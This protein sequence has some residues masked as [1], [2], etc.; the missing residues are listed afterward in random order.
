[1]HVG[2]RNYQAFFQTV[3]HLL[4]RAGLVLLHTMGGNTSRAYCDPW[5]NKYIFPHGVIPSVSQLGRAIE[6]KFVVE[7][8]HCFG[9]DYFRT[10][11][12]W[13]D[14]FRKNWNPTTV[15][16]SFMPE[17]FFRMWEYYLISFGSAFRARRLNVWQLVL[18]R[19]GELPCYEPIR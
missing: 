13:C 14:G 5:V 2:P 3:D 19:I 15:K 7:D 16:T 4:E 8:W 18:S 12:N 10:F 6:G 11:M 9:P 17:K 1:E